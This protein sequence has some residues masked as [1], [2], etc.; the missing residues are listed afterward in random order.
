MKRLAF[1]IVFLLV[2]WWQYATIRHYKAECERYKANTAILMSEMQG[3]KVMDSLNAVKV[4]A[5][6]LSLDEYKRLRKEDYNLARSLDIKPKHLQSII[7]AQLQTATPLFSLIRDTIIRTERDTAIYKC[8]DVS[9]HWVD[10]HGCANETGTFDGILIS[11]DSLMIAI[12]TRYRRFLG[13]LWKTNKVKSR[14]TDIVSRNP[15]TKITGAEFVFID[16]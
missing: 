7:T 12:T 14:H 10:L 15:N 3:Y 16:N 13:F 5:V 2:V 9:T 4:G 6:T 1:F 8:I 11:R